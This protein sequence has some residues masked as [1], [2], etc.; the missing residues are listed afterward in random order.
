MLYVDAANAT[1]V[2]MYERL[3]FRIAR[4]DVAFTGLVA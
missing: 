4:T 2:G 3:G 1:A